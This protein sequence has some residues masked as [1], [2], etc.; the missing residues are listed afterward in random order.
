MSD[1][2][3]EVPLCL[4]EQTWMVFRQDDNGICFVLQSGLS[5]EAAERMA[6]EFQARGHKQLYW[7]EPEK[8][9]RR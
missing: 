1:S 4:R 5:Q 6:A 2:P 3:P 9:Q 8:N 7:A